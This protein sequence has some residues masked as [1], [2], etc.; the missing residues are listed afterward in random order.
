MAMFDISIAN[1][2]QIV[3]T[4]GGWLGMHGAAHAG[5]A[6]SG[7]RVAACSKESAPPLPLRRD[8]I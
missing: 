3:D 6:P 8:E 2:D 1:V 4:V 7:M 5:K